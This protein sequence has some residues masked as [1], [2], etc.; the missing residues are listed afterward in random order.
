[1]TKRTMLLA[2]PYS[3]P[4]R[5]ATGILAALEDVPKPRSRAGVNFLLHTSHMA[6]MNCK[7][8]SNWSDGTC[9][10]SSKTMSTLAFPKIGITIIQ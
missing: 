1:M 8:D 5:M 9:P 2:H 4:Q 7:E 10:F 3:S 6:M